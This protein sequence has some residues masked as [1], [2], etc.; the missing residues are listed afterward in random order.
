MSSSLSGGSGPGLPRRVAAVP[1]AVQVDLVAKGVH[2]LPEALVTEGG[3]LA[4]VRQ[5]LERRLGPVD[6][7]G[8]VVE[9]ARLEHEESAVD[10][11]LDHARLLVEA[12]DHVAFHLEPTE[13]GGRVDGGDGGEPTMGFVELHEVGDVDVGDAVAVG[14]EGRLAGG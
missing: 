4:G 14:E 13:A 12:F 7:A 10:P 3:Q 9:D 6:V 2:A 8:D 11:A 1:E 5:A